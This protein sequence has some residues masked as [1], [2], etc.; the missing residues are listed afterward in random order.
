[1]K[2]QKVLSLEFN[3]SGPV[4]FS[5]EQ[6]AYLD[7]GNYSILVMGGKTLTRSRKLIAYNPVSG[8]ILVKEKTDWDDC[9]YEKM[10]VVSAEGKPEK[11]KGGNF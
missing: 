5:L 9:N 1:M 7:S 4:L 2:E 6:D 8:N 3:N 11:Y 10:F